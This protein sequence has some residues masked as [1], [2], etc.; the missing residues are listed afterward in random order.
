MAS[1]GHLRRESLSC[2]G[3]VVDGLVRLDR[4]PRQDNVLGLEYSSRV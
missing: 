2:G 4:G 3:V 1:L